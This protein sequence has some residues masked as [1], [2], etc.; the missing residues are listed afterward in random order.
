[1]Q[2]LGKRVSSCLQAVTR[3]CYM[4]LISFVMIFISFFMWGY[5]AMRISA[6]SGNCAL[7]CVLHSTCAVRT[8]TDIRGS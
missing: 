3:A 6:S 4:I 2:E 7:T 8:A 1:M 5:D